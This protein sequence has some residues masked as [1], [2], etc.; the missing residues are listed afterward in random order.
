MRTTAGLQRKEDFAGVWVSGAAV[1]SDRGTGVGYGEC[2]FLLTPSS[3]SS[4][5]RT[6]PTSLRMGLCRGE[7]ACPGRLRVD[8]WKEGE[9]QRGFSG[10]R[11][12]GE[13]WGLSGE[14]PVGET[15]DQ[16]EN[17]DGIHGPTGLPPPIAPI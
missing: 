13:A 3:S 15:R 10:T 2:T 6:L 7:G 11:D 12:S 14:A 17:A 16:G 5:S 4:S 9:R 1:L 8:I